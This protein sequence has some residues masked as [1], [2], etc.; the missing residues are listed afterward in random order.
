LVGGDHLEVLEVVRTVPEKR[1]VCR[2]RW[3][4]RDVFAKLFLDKKA[5]TYAQRDQLGVERLLAGDIATP[6]LLTAA[7]TVESN[8]P[9]LVYE[10]ILGSQ[11]AET[12]YQQLASNER[13]DLVLALV[14]T[15]AQHHKVGLI[16]TDLHLKNFLLQK[17]HI[18]TLDGDGIRSIAQSDHDQMLGNLCVFLSKLD[19][20]DLE[21]WRVALLAAYHAVNPDLDINSAQLKSRTDQHRIKASTRY[22][23]EKVFR[24]CTDVAVNKGTD[25]YHAQSSVYQHLEVPANLAA[26]DDLVNAGEMLKDGNTCTVVSSLLS[27]QAVVIKRYNLKSAG[28]AFGRAFRKRRRLGVLRARAYFISAYIDALDIAEYFANNRDKKERAAAMKQ[29][30]ALFYRLYLLKISHG[31]MKATNIKMLTDGKPSL[32]DLD[33]MQQHT[34]DAVALKA[35]ARDIKRFMRNWDEQPALFNAF[36]KVFKVVYPD[37]AALHA[38]QI[39]A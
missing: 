31:D 8:H 24:V 35:H 3:Q 32:I 16:Q 28:H 23:D 39:L 29:T 2:A 36:V 33:S 4:G 17:Q 15:I 27:E 12:A 1:V 37:H 11:D 25:Y 10:A 20:L 22:A 5:E 34:T 30:V 21:A 6:A 18:Y 13:K 19:V 7:K 14:E 26:Y 9:V 38:A